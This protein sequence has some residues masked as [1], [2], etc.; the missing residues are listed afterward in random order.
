MVPAQGACSDLAG[1]GAS[2][3]ACGAGGALPGVPGQSA[4]R[5]ISVA[6]SRP[7]AA[8]SP[9]IGRFLPCLR[10]TPPRARSK[11]E[12]AKAAPFCMRET[13]EP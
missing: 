8:N 10:L 2:H 7:G 9:K 3:P 12:R 4:C 1:I 11:R 13:K 5:M 6:S